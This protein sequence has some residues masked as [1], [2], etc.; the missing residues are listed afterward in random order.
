MSP[1]RHSFWDRV[2]R[3]RQRLT[4]FLSYS[5][6]DGSTYAQ[7]LT[8]QLSGL[9]IS[10]FLAHRDLTPGSLWAAT[11]RDSL[12]QADVLILIGSPNALRSRSVQSEVDF[13]LHRRGRIIPIMFPDAMTREEIPPGLHEINWIIEHQSALQKGPSE[14][15]IQLILKALGYFEEES[16]ERRPKPVQKKRAEQKGA[17]NEGKLILVGRGE[18]GKTSIVRRLVD[19]DF[20]GDE[21][22]T[23]GI[24]ITT[25][26]LKC[27]EDTLRLNIWDF[28]GQEIMHATHQF[29]LTERSLYILVLN[30]REGGED[31][32]AEYW[33]KHIESFGGNSPV[34]I[35]QNKIAQ[36]PF[37][38][39]YRGLQARYPQVHGF[40]KTDCEGG[41]GIDVLREKISEVA[42]GMPEVR[43]Q[44]PMDWFRV[45][46]RSIHRT[47]THP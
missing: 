37:E 35:V 20:R 4:C 14:E 46:E 26:P 7:S 25:W 22:K 13:F 21:T 16:R 12:Q 9:E 36:H 23:Q 3:R 39:N 1:N 33:M 42:A 38:L 11:I 28:G 6:K 31:I 30:G 44:F 18:V 10:T 43:M 27:A 19:D 32:D 45:K 34:I 17:L 2:T 5:Y 47:F 29:F 15:A 8:E 24:N 40:V 41:I